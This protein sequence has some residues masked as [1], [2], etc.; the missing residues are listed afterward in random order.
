MAAKQGT[1]CVS[2]LFV[3]LMLGCAAGRR[4]DLGVVAGKLSPC[5]SAS[6]CVS[7]QA[8]DAG[9]AIE[10]IPYHESR[11]ETRKRL[12][13]ILRSMPRAQVLTE[14][15][16]Y[17]HAVFPTRAGGIFG[18][19]DDVEVYLDD[20]AKLVHLRSSS[21]TG[22]FDFGANRSRI[23]EIRRKVLSARS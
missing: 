3:A 18:C 4:S 5:P 1:Q 20:R 11:D 16:D 7:T 9:H 23:E 2:A 8:T 6:P 15:S 13:A 10:P 19:A 14:A 12:V 21:C 17:V 22:Y